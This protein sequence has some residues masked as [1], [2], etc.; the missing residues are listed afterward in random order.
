L[1][2]VGRPLYELARSAGFEVY[3]FDVD[4]SRSVDSLDG[5]PR[6]VDY[7]HV[8]IPFRGLEGFVEAVRGYAERVGARAIV[9]HSTVAPG[10]TR[11]LHEATGLPV[12]YSPVR[13]RH[14]RLRSHMLF[15]PKWVA[16]LPRERL[17]DFT[18]HLEAMGFSVKP[19]TCEPES[20]ELAKLWET[21]YRAVMIAAWQELHRYARAVGAD[22]TVVAEFVAEVHQVLGDRPVYYPGYIGG[23]CL[24]P[25]VEIMLS[26]R[27]SRLLEAVIE[28]NRAR[29]EE[30]RDEKL[31]DE[32]ERIRK[33]WEQLTPHWYYG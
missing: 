14:P 33:I 10:T 31:R 7:L 6:P 11:R 30:L 5:V 27:R 32:V 19:C 23:H 4:P 2:Q 9:V 13:G 3:G 17:S 1:G 28:S 24:I 21:A 8:A 25:N 20:L 16:A 26:L 15:W 18:S 22:P 12:A 29:A